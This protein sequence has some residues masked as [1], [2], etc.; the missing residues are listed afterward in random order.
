[1]PWWLDFIILLFMTSRKRIT[2]IGA[3]TTSTTTLCSSRLLPGKWLSQMSMQRVSLTYHYFQKT[4]KFV[5]YSQILDYSEHDC[6]SKKVL[7]FLCYIRFS[8]I[9]FYD[10]TSKFLF[11]YATMLWCDTYFFLFHIS[12]AFFPSSYFY[13]HELNDDDWFVF[14]NGFDHS[15]VYHWLSYAK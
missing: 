1:M 15:I 9:V 13:F 11:L 14:L 8:Q 10:L 3:A 5:R 7:S 4:L 12:C 2:I 6:F